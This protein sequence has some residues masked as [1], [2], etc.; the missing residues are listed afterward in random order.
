MFRM[1]IAAAVLAVPT[2]ALAA[3][4]TV[5]VRAI[6]ANGVGA[7]VGTVTYKDTKRGLV[8]EPKL[9][10]LPPGP[11]GF[12]VHENGDC[13]PGPGADGRPAPGM[14]AGGHYDP[15]STKAHMGPHAKAG[16]LGDLPVLV[17]DQDGSA[18]LPVLA[19]RLKSG[20]LRGRALMVHAGGDN[21]ADQPAALGG[22]GARIACGTIAKARPTAKKR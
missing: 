22:G 12:H 5:T 11:H 1:L 3:T 13:G 7:E 16:H 2:A 9:R 4:G 21:Y 19:P 6:D 17:V 20:N 8:L 10:G 15:K 18:T 14:A